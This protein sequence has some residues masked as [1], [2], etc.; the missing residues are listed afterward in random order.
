VE[1]NKRR[2]LLWVCLAYI[3]AFVVGAAVAVILRELSPIERALWADVAATVFVF[4][5][6]RL[7]G[8]SSMYDPYWS[9]APPVL[10]IFWIAAYR[11]GLVAFALNASSAEIVPAGVLM[12]A[13][14]I[15][16][17]RLTANWARRWQGFNDEDWRYGMLKHQFGRAEMVI[18]FLGVHFF[19]TLIVFLALLPV[20]SALRASSPAD[21]GP[22]LIPLSVGIALF[23]VS[24]ALEWIA[25]NQLAAFRSDSR[26][27]GTI[28]RSGVW[29][30]VRHPNYVGEM[31]F[32]WGLW[33]VSYAAGAAFWT[34][35]GPSAMTLMFV[36]ISIPMMN[37][38]LANRSI[39]ADEV[40]RD[41]DTS[42]Y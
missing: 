11:E 27:K 32:W 10:I 3:G 30:L 28:L 41:S 14:V 16:S 18:D 21:A 17:F 8:N 6:S 22:P 25:D 26:N 40:E 15:W 24:I 23:V 1:P 38:R 2:A 34:I 9:V 33:A 7:T 29:G 36:G 37:R 4:V 31:L 20:A 39:R 12:A 19:P 13:V 42:V 35:A 5:A